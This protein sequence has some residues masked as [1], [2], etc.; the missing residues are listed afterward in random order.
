M[1][2]VNGRALTGALVGSFVVLLFTLGVLYSQGHT[3]IE[4]NA[5][6]IR[7]LNTALA[8]LCIQRTDLDNH[9][10][11]TNQLLRATRGDATVFGIPRI[12]IIESQR[13]NLILR[14]SLEI[15][16]CAREGS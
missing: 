5:D 14:R 3:R 12:V 6:Q 8:A 13:Q 1:K 10:E 9:I 7:K 16:Q 15:L 11:S 2:R 4:Q